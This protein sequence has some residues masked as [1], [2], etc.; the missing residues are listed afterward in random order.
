MSPVLTTLND[1]T[2]A[3]HDPSSTNT[4]CNDK[5]QTASP[6]SAIAEPIVEVYQIADNMA[7][8]SPTT[9]NKTRSP[10]CPDS[11][12]S[13]QMSRMTERPFNSPLQHDLIR[14]PSHPVLG[15]PFSEQ[16]VYYAITIGR[17]S[18]TYIRRHNAQLQYQHF[19]GAI[20]AI[21][22]SLQQAEEFIHIYNPGNIPFMPDS[23]R[24]IRN[25]PP[26]FNAFAP[27]AEK[28]WPVPF[29][30][31]NTDKTE[32]DLRTHAYSSQLSCNQDKGPTKTPEEGSLK[33][34]I[35]AAANY[36]CYVPVIMN[37]KASV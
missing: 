24:G 18:D 12:A 16:P 7:D 33:S 2:S 35:A 26:R 28:H 25:P 36:G 31:P 21:C 22:K 1:D 37:G 15:K 9:P 32:T 34:V 23:R 5:E 8:Q 13:M 27:E 11:A 4:R 6:I 14:L 10:E 20:W 3:E 19:D 30:N 17:N 29:P